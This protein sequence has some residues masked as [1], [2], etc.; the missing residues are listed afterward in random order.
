MFGS[1]VALVITVVCS[2]MIHAGIQAQAQQ[3]CDLLTIDEIHTLEPSAQ[4][5]DGVANVMPSFESF[6]CRY[7]WA[8]GI[9][10]VSL[11]V[12][13]NPASRA[14]AGLS[15]DA[16]KQ[17]FQQ[18]VAEGT[19]DASLPDIGEAGVF[20]AYSSAYVSASAYLKGRLLQVSLSGID[21]RE[22]KAQV[23][24]LLK[25]AASRL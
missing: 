17:I 8:S 14:F 25:A 7:L 22:K 10:R 15:A 18:S 20:K 21:A 6:S 9:E 13:V 11:A 2:S 16:I 3:P 12:S 23:I 24:S 19:T 1:V 5:H 4:A